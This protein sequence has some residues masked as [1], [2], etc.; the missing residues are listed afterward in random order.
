MSRIKLI[1]ALVFCVFAPLCVRAQSVTVSGTVTDKDTGDPVEFATIVIEAS[2]QWA[3]ADAKGRFSIRN[4]SA[5]KSVVTV[6]CLGYVTLDGHNAVLPELS[7]EGI[8][9]I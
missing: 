4:V 7:A 1:L 6:D 5:S 3:V 8:R 9:I 2:E